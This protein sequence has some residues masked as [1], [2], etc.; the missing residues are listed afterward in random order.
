MSLTT[1]R[2]VT[3]PV[4]FHLLSNLIQS[5]VQPF[6]CC[7]MFLQAYINKSASFY[8]KHDFE[9]LVGTS[10]FDFYTAR[11]LGIPCSQAR[12]KGDTEMVLHGTRH[13]ILLTC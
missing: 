6:N 7:E 9:I 8:V 3:I 1:L 4:S 5:F 13:I 12:W 11:K 10:L 2:F